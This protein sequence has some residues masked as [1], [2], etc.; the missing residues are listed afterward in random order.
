MHRRLSLLI[1]VVLVGALLGFY[2]LYPPLTLVDGDDHEQTNVTV[3]AE[4]GTEL[5]T[6]DA[7]LAETREQR[8]I[9]LSRTDS[10]ENGSGML[11][12]HSEPDTQSY[13]M[14]NMSFGLDIVF[15]APNGTITEI[16]DAPHP[17]EAGTGPYSGFGQYI[18][19]V[20]RGWMD[21]IGA[22]VGDTIEIPEPIEE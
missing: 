13:V 8:R 21:A 11:F 2:T 4:N 1:L 10:L 17:D 19:E 7:K 14:R 22:T 15:I 18:L 3:A 12:V 16:H 20:P 9:G 6:V 5:A